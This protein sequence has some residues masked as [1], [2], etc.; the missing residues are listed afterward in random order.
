MKAHWKIPG[1]LTPREVAATNFYYDK[2]PDSPEYSSSLNRRKLSHYMHPE[3]N[4]EN[5]L[6][7]PKLREAF[8]T[9]TVTSAAFTNWVKPVEI[10]TDSWQPHE[11]R[12]LDMGW[13]VLVPLRVTP[14][15]A[16]TATIIF[17]QWTEEGTTSL[18]NYTQDE[19]WNIAEYVS[20]DDGRI[21]NKQ[22]TNMSPDWL[23]DNLPH[24]DDPEMVRNFTVGG[25]YP[26]VLGDAIVWDRR[27]FHTSSGFDGLESKLHAIFFV[28]KPY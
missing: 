28:N 6:F 15:S 23:R 8:P 7:G 17:D 12:S 26:W 21:Q 19:A 1:F 2:L 11:D 13:V 22:P 27:Y 9:G 5:A 25:I 20:P 24:I 4:F 16:R 3:A 14:T 10:H 18:A